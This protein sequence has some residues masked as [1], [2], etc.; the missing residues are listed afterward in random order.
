M[1]SYSTT[2]IGSKYTQSF[3]TYITC[4]GEV[5]SPFHDIPYKSGVYYNCVNEI[6]RFEHAKFE[7]SKADKFNPIMQDIKKGKIRFVK[8]V[9]PMLGHPFNYGAI[10]QTWESPKHKDDE[11]G[12]FGDNDPI[13]VIEIGS[14]R[15]EIGEIYQGKVLGAYA[16]LD[17][18]ESDWKIV[19]IDSKDELADKLNNIADIHEHCP[20]MLEHIHIFL[21]DCKLL[22]GKPQNAFAFDGKFLDANAAVKVI[23]RMHLNWKELIVTGYEGIELSNRNIKESKSN[24]TS[25]KAEGKEEKDAECPDS[26]WAYSYV[27]K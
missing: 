7:V 23:E 26:L 10:P 6:P 11:I 13:D 1:D 4:N 20:K 15:K 25:F 14:R 18:G 27:T 8:N 9:F 22:D 21:R 2:K 24:C 19:V 5:L 17:D 16:L 3:K 12:A